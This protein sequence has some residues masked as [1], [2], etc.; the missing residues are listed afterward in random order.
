MSRQIIPLRL[1]EYL[2]TYFGNRMAALPEILRNG[3]FEDPFLVSAQTEYG[4]YILK[5]LST[6][7]R[8]YSYDKKDH[9]FISIS[10]YAGDHNADTVRGHRNF[11]KLSK[12]AVK[13]I[14]TKFN[15]IF[16]NQLITFVRGAESVTYSNSENKRVRTRAI[17]LFC[18]ENHVLYSDK[19][20]V[21]WKKMCQRHK[22]SDKVLIYNIL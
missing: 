11:M 15:A 3:S 2:A 10:N 7:N 9:F 17:R 14:E 21:A 19:N 16:R 1:P 18:E 6:A 22:K 8:P 5:N 12:A 20:L 4:E 13:D